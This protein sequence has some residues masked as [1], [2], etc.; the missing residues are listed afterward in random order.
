M[1][2]KL[3]FFRQINLSIR[4]RK[5]ETPRTFVTIS[6]TQRY[7]AID[8]FYA[9]LIGFITY[10]AD[11]AQATPSLERGKDYFGY[12]I[13]QIYAQNTKLIKRP[14][15]FGRQLSSCGYI[16]STHSLPILQIMGQIEYVQRFLV[17]IFVLFL[18]KPFNFLTMHM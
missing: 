10:A 15:N 8:I 14:D 5:I 2:L 1:Q 4:F 3:T 6:G 18:K 16:Y 17:T 9:L 12:R 13:L 11:F 7:N